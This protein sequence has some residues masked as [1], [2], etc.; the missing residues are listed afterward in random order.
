M[1]DHKVTMLAATYPDEEHAKTTLDMLERMHQGLTITLKDSAMITRDA[2]G[3]VKIHESKEVTTKKGAK[4]G[5]VV[6]AVLGVIYPPS[7]LMS[8]ALGGAIGGLLGKVRDTGIKNP[9]LK[10]MA[11]RLQPGQAAIVALVADET[12]A[13]AQ[14]AL[15]G[16][17]GTLVSEPVSEE[18]MNRITEAEA[19]DQTATGDTPSFR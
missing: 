15:K 2:D 18:M 6:G 4:R 11:D 9:R 1:S 8:G 13:A 10:E 3:K 17:E 12:L 19:S 7:L 5:I 14:G 16:Y